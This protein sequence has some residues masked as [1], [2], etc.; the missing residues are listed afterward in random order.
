MSAYF[1]RGLNHDHVAAIRKAGNGYPDPAPA[2]RS[3]V[4]TEGGAA[5]SA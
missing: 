2:E 3:Q 4:A 5:L 1:H